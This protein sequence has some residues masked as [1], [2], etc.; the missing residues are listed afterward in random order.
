[1]TG[2][3]VLGPR[4][5][6]DEDALPDD[7]DDDDLKDDPI[8]RMDMTVSRPPKIFLTITTYF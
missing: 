1:M 3:D 6:F 7:N 2:K 5:A 8:S 4:G